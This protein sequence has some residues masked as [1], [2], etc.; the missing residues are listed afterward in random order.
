MTEER[1]DD[2]PPSNQGS[3]YTVHNDTTVTETDKGG[4]TIDAPG[5]S[6]T[7]NPSTGETTHTET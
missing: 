3:T 7:V 2:L 5:H 1:E 4:V 6:V